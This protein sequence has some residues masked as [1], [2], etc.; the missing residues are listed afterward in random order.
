MVEIPPERKVGL[1]LK[2]SRKK[3]WPGFKYLSKERFALVEKYQEREVGIGLKISRLQKE[4]L[5]WL[6]NTQKE[7]LTL[8]KKSPERKVGLG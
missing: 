5:A 4:R 1:G 6:K 7:R 3:G 8:V 2:I